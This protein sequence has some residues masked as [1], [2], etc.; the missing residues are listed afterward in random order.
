MRELREL[1]IGIGVRA[2]NGALYWCG[3]HFIC[4]VF[5]NKVN[6]PLVSHLSLSAAHTWR[7]EKR[8]KKK[9]LWC[10]R[11]FWNAALGCG[12]HLINDI[13]CGK[14]APVQSAFEAAHGRRRFPRIS[15]RVSS[16]PTATNEVKLVNL[17]R[18]TAP[19]AERVMCEQCG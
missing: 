7:A 2:Q 15:F 18:N 13:R 11:D 8:V 10:V 5:V 19:Q 9:H 17:M 12:M 1:G 3:V 16:I 14:V 6:M 4:E